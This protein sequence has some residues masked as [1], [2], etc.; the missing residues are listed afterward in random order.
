MLTIGGGLAGCLPTEQG[1]MYLHD[2]A[3]LGPYSGSVLAGNY[4]FVS[5]K[6]GNRS[7]TFEH[8]VDTAI[9]AVQQELARAGLT[10]AHVVSVTVFV[11]DIATYSQFNEVYARRFAEP[12]PARAMVQVVALPGDARVEIQAIARRQ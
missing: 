4:C 8:E 12:H 2:E 3:A 1:T 10:L 5:G 11:T 7:G 6:I 9:E